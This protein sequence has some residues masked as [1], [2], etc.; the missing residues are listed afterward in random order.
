MEDMARME[1]R[2]PRRSPEAPVLSHAV[3]RDSFVGLH[4]RPGKQEHLP[5]LQVVL[6][7]IHVHPLVH[8]IV[9]ALEQDTCYRYTWST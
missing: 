2:T 8:K 7:H 4:L 5:R 3:H 6:V 9:H 1:E